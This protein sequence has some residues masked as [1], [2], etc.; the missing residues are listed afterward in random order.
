LVVR[1]HGNDRR[2]EGVRAAKEIRRVC[3]FWI[4]QDVVHDGEPAVVK[5]FPSRKQVVLDYTSETRKWASRLVPVK[6]VKR[7]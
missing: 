1:S 5:S 2:R 7:V 6:E 3:G 4:G